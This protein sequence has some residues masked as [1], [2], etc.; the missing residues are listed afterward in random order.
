MPGDQVFT[1]V[2]DTSSM[3]LQA[4]ATAFGLE[5]RPNPVVESTRILLDIS[6]DTRATVTVLDPTGRTVDQLFD[7]V[8]EAGR[9]SVGW[10]GTDAAGSR[11]TP[12][13]YLVEV[14]FRGGGMPRSGW[15][16]RCWW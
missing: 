15:S 14:R 10:A 9:R 7:G 6:Q 2:E 11:V 1:V 3:R 16:S 12:G 13:M 8:F 4:P 5:V